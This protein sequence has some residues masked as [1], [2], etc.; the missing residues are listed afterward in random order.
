MCKNDEDRV[1]L[2]RVAAGLCIVAAGRAVAPRGQ[3][4]M[5]PLR[6]SECSAGRLH[7]CTERGQ[8]VQSGENVHC[9]EATCSLPVLTSAATDESAGARGSCRH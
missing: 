2:T 3:P 6:G 9:R 8:S 7:W 4:L 5:S 1:G